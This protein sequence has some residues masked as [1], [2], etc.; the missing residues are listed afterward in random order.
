[1]KKIDINKYWLGYLTG[2]LIYINLFSAGVILSYTLLL[3]WIY[4]FWIW[5]ITTP[6][7]LTINY[8]SKKQKSA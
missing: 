2:I 8:L 7:L 3:N 6:I 1:M 4:F 5:L